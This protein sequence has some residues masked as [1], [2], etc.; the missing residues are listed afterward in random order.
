MKSWITSILLACFTIST[1]NAATSSKLNI[2]LD[3]SGSMF[4]YKE[5]IAQSILK[6]KQH[7]T[8]YPHLTESINLYSFT[9][10]AQLLLEGD[11]NNVY[12]SIKAIKSGGGVEDGLI[13][14]EK[15]L[16]NPLIADTH[17]ILFTDEGRDAVKEIELDK[18]ITLATNKNITIHSVLRTS[19]FCNSQQIIGI[20]HTFNG[21]SANQELLECR[22]INSVDSLNVL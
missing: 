22:A 14:I 2:V 17:I 20:D 12:S 19:N 21:Y 15:I 1:V 3:T 8:N 7:S 11:S 13:A 5:G 9:D 4:R 6:I 16:E 10:Q 18:L